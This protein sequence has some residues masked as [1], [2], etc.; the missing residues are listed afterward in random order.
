MIRPAHSWGR[1]HHHT[2]PGAPCVACGAS[3]DLPPRSAPAPPP[4]PQLCRFGPWPVAHGLTLAPALPKDCRPPGL[5][6]DCRPPGLPNDCRPPPP[7][8]GGSSAPN[9]LLAPERRRLESR[10]WY[11]P[12]PPPP[13]SYRPPPPLRPLYTISGMLL[14]TRSGRLV[15]ASVTSSINVDHIQ[16]DI[17]IRGQCVFSSNYEHQTL[18]VTV[19]IQ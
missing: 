6:N 18:Q 11:P 15:T 7:P 13:P 17:N 14:S 19:N 5:P 3:A 12:P 2:E 1:A 16:P 8:M 10:R 9:W 4:L